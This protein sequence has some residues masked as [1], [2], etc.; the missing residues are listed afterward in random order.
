LYW[1]TL[2]NGSLG[3]M[4]V[5]G[6]AEG[7][8]RPEVKRLRV[9]Y[10]AIAD[11]YDETPGRTRQVD[12][13]LL[14][15]TGRQAPADR[16]AVLDIGCG[17][18]NQLVANRAACAF[19]LM[20]G[21]DRSAGMLRQARGKDLEILW[22]QA[23]GAALPVGDNSFDF[24]T[25]QFAFHHI[26]DKAGVIRE[27]FRVLRRGGRF[28]IRNLCP[29]ESLD[30]LY[31]LYFP[32]ALTVDLADFSPPKSIEAEME[33]A[34]FGGVTVALQHLRYAQDLRGLLDEARRRHSCSQLTAISDAAYEAGLSR[35]SRELADHRGPMS[36][37][38]HLCLVTIRGERPNQAKR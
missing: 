9:D 14:A 8:G 33:K 5:A 16:L 12:P 38:N 15:F 7:C 37:E 13:E 23:D 30:W 3:A 1:G 20:V 26:A 31:Y 22:V 35:L 29:Q 2:R 19:A 18:G 21:L 32:E 36:R 28:V 6:E 4:I 11:L 17:T 10:D 24:V 34:G 27:A 25:C